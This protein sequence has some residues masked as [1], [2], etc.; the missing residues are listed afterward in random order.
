M[1]TV[2]IQEAAH[3]LGVSVDTVRR[4]IRSGALAARK[5]A[6]PQGH[7]WLVEVPATQPPDLLA[8]KQEIQRLE[9]VVDHLQRS[10]TMANGELTARRNEVARLLTLLEARLQGSAR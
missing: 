7:Q 5:D 6:R 4:R 8:A 10:L 9:E 2:T 1:A 3:Q